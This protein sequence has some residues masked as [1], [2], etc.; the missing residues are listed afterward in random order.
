[1]FGWSQK[2]NIQIFLCSIVWKKHHKLKRKNHA[3]TV[4]LLRQYNYYYGNTTTITAIRLLLRQYDY[5]YGNTINITAIQLI[6]HSYCII[7]SLS[8]T[9]N[10]TEYPQTATHI[11]CCRTGNVCICLIF[12]FS[13]V[14]SRLQKFNMQM[15]LWLIVYWLAAR[16]P[17][18]YFCKILSQTKMQRL[19]SQKFSVLWYQ[20]FTPS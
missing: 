20:T 1:M 6:L 14:Y 19:R 16:N 13:R 9:H 10:I 8:T 17:K 15:I 5:Y 2:L 18:I 12:V 11:Y 7:P 4:L 3:S